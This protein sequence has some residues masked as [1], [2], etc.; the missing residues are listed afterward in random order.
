[1]MNVH[2]PEKI[3]F[4]PSHAPCQ[5]PVNTPTKTDSRPESVFSTTDKMLELLVYDGEKIV[6]PDGK[7][8][9]TGISDIDPEEFQPTMWDL[10][11]LLR[12]LWAAS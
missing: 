10:Y 7:I 11:T 8:D 9:P 3:C 1:M 2:T 6:Y 5:S 12:L 4:T